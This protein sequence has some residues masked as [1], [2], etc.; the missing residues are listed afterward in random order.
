MR[1]LEFVGLHVLP[2]GLDDHGPRLSVDPQ[3][4]G[5]SGVQLKLRRL[6]KEQFVP[7]LTVTHNVEWCH[8]LVVSE[9]QGLRLE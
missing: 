1:V 4:P 8:L 3:Q 2:Q 9:E 5:K 7:L 6:E